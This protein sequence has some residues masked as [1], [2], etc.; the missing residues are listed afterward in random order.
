MNNMP[1][2][3]GSKLVCYLRD[4]GGREQDKSIPQQEKEIGEFCLEHKYIMVRLFKDEARSGKNVKGRTEF[5]AMMD[6]FE[7]KPDVSGLILW[8]FSRFAR[9]YSDSQFYINLIRHLGYSVYSITEAI[10]DTTEG[11][12]IESIYHYKNAKYLEDLRK[13]VKRGLKYNREVYH[14]NQ[15]FI[16]IG[17]KGKQIT[18]GSRRGKTNGNETNHLVT[19]LEIDPHNAPKVKKAFELR[20]MGWTYKEINNELHLYKKIPGYP[21]MFRNTKYAG[22]YED[23]DEYCPPIVTRELFDKVQAINKQRGAKVGVHHPRVLRSRFILSGLLHCALCGSSMYAIS[24]ANKSHKRYDYYRCCRYGKDQCN[25]GN[26]PKN[27]LES[28][29]IDTIVNKIVQQRDVVDD[30]YLNFIEAQTKERSIQ[31]EEKS[32]IESDLKTNQSEIDNITAAIR[33]QGYSRALLENLA[34]LEENRDNLEIELA[35]QDKPRSTLYIPDFEKF[36]NNLP[37]KLHE[38]S[39]KGKADLLRSIIKRIDIQKN[40]TDIAGKIELTFPLFD[41]NDMFISLDNATQVP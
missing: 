23:I 13:N 37:S 16:P 12:L 22:Y 10:P 38:V 20:A 31:D 11:Q 5:I 40:G 21:V 18:I 2:P 17:F 8:E 33:E 1:F 25:N 32:R 9:D 7:Q 4:S 3:I 28:M 41:S 26:I 14:A 29:V 24:T 39:D 15:G 6:Y 19:I 36:I 27:Q 34:K 35:N 30:S